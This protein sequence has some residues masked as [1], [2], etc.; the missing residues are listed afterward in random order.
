MTMLSPIRAI[1]IARLRELCE[2]IER[3]HSD[4]V[5]AV[6]AVGN[7][8]AVRLGSS[9]YAIAAWYGYIDLAD[10]AWVEA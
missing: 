2:Q 3:E 8:N 6:N 5:I 7:L 4:A 10:E 9:Q 1:P